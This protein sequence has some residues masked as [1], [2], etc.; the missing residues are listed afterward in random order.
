ML[1]WK[2]NE[3]HEIVITNDME[4]IP[5]ALIE[6]YVGEFHLESLVQSATLQ[7]QDTQH[8]EHETGPDHQKNN[9]AI[10]KGHKIATLSGI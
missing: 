10:E 8:E 1:K 3:G 6:E 9:V 2:I 5:A 4:R 7:Q